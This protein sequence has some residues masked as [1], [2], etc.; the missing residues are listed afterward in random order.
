V[1]LDEALRMEEVEPY[2]KNAIRKLIEKHGP[3]SSPRE[4][5]V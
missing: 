1:T 5:S 2:A 3:L 4:D